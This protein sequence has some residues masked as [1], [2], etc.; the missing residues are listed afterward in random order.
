M[1]NKLLSQSSK[2]EVKSSECWVYVQIAFFNM[3]YYKIVN[4]LAANSR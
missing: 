4:R 2:L 3:I 1:K